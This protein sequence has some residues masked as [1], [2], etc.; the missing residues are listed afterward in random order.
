MVAGWNEA[1]LPTLL[2][3]YDLE[4]IYN[5]DEFGLSYQCSPNKSYQLKT[6]M[7]RW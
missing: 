2:S 4:N 3:N 5:A 6:E 1:T 7:F